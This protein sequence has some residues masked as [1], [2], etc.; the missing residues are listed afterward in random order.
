MRLLPDEFDPDSSP[1]GAIVTGQIQGNKIVVG[2]LVGRGGQSQVYRGLVGRGPN[3]GQQVAVKFF[4]VPASSEWESYALRE[5][6]V[7]AKLD[8]P[9]APKFI[10]YGNCESHGLWLALE[11]VHGTNL[12]HY[13]RTSGPFRG[14]DAEASLLSMLCQLAECVDALRER[15][16]L[17]RDIKPGN[18]MVNADGQLI[19]LDFGMA[20]SSDDLKLT[21]HAAIKGTPA[22]MAPETIM[23][24]RDSAADVYSSAA[25]VYF[26]ATGH[27]PHKVENPHDYWQVA[28]AVLESKPIPLDKACPGIFSKKFSALLS[29]AMHPSPVHRPTPASLAAAAKQL[30]DRA[31]DD[32][33]LAVS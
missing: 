30:L 8:F 22:F 33:P 21:S 2:E 10:D 23:G 25:T 32:V 12:A 27:P 17:H 6:R 11:F 15:E 13:V 14:P 31:P 18:L 24:R 1:E 3:R 29:L 16:I 7:L 9:W 20:K 19:V 28:L 26:C 5:A 4:G